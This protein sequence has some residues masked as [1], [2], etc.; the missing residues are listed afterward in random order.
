[1]DHLGLVQ[2]VDRFGQCVGASSQLR[3]LVTLNVDLSG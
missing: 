2:P 1:M 3:R